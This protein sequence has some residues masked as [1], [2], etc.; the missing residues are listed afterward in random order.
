MRLV[1][2]R[3][4]LALALVC[5]IA[6]ATPAF[7]QPQMPS[8]LDLYTAIPQP[9]ATPHDAATWFDASGTLVHPGLVAL[10][11]QIATHK[12]GLE[13]R[14]TDV[15]V[16]AVPQG[17]RTVADLG[18]GMANAGIDMTRMQNDPA[19][20]QQVQAR[21]QSMTPQQLMELS[22]KMSQP[23]NDDAGL[24]N[25]AKAAAD[26]PAVVQAAAEAA[27][28]AVLDQS[29]RMSA[30]QAVW[31]TNEAAI[32]KITAAP[33]TPGRP[34]PTQHIGEG[35]GASCIAAWEAYES[36]LAAAQIARDGE[37]LALRRSAFAQARSDAA[38]FIREADTHLKATKY[39]DLSSSQH[40]KSLIQNL[41]G[42]ALGEVEDLV[43]RLED[44]A[45][46]ASTTVRAHK[47]KARTMS[48]RQ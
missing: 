40:N 5:P 47:A 12:Q 48:S 22:M 37:V 33:L 20:A 23:M 27:Q 14:Q 26:D 30:N 39:G 28:R 17:L 6:V 3:A 10:K 1:A 19:Y 44:I 9:P 43:T 13:A 4:A 45:R 15:S 16:K 25:Q 46:T 8:V 31:Q 11:Q 35:C 7:A 36:A 42:A 32:A 21:L 34:K 18:A 38:P 24:V 41:D 2:H 29:E